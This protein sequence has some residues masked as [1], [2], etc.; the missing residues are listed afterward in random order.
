MLFFKNIYKPEDNGKNNAYQNGSG[1]GEKEMKVFPFYVD[2][3][4]KFSKKRN[5]I[6]KNQQNTCR[7]KD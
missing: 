7:N 5:F 6:K 3:T 4:W 2:I 1:Q